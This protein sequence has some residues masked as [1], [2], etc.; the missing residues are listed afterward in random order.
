M[1]VKKVL[2]KLLPTT[3]K[4]GGL[5]TYTITIAGPDD[6]TGQRASRSRA[7]ATSTTS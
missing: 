1:D 7:P 3:N 5:T 6:V 4:P 2:T